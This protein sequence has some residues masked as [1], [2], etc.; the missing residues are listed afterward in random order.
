ML[1]HLSRLSRLSRPSRLSRLSILLVVTMAPA[2]NVAAQDT[3]PSRFLRWAHQDIGAAFANVSTRHGLYLLGGAT[4]IAGVSIVDPAIAHEVKEG[5]AND[6][7]AGYFDIAN[8]FG[9]RYATVPVVAVFATSLA[10][11]NTRFQDASFTSLQSLVYSSTLNFTIKFIT[12]RIRPE[13]RD[14]Q[15]KFRPFSGNSSFPSGHTNAAFSILIPWAMY[16]PHPVTY[17]VVGVAATG[18]AMARISRDKHWASDVLAGAAEGALVG[19]L[20]SRRHIRIQRS[21]EVA[22]RTGAS[23]RTLRLADVSIVPGIRTNGGSLSIIVRL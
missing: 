8:E 12:G 19:Y 1:S 13:D 5:Y 6:V 10:T 20:L 4:V 3:S 22:E 9:G 15:Y 18:T 21:A 7:V 2:P 14:H 23:N 11:R 16:Y 17:V